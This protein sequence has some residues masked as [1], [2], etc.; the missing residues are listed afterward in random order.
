MWWWWL[1]TN[2]IQDSLRKP[3]YPFL[4]LI[5][6]GFTCFC[7]CFP[8]PPPLGHIWLDIYLFYLFISHRWGVISSLVIICRVWHMI[9]LDLIKGLE[10]ENWLDMARNFE[11][12]CPPQFQFYNSENKLLLMPL[13]YIIGS[14][15]LFRKFW[16]FFPYLI[17]YVFA[18][19]L[20]WKYKG[21]ENRTATNYVIILFLFQQAPL[22]LWLRKNSPLALYLS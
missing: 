7:F 15:G 5:V 14:K 11:R 20:Y 1:K 4:L 21:K 3:S 9:K 13:T 19:D 17:S 8:L 22:V 6:E 2:W 18:N 16:R 12:R 10:H